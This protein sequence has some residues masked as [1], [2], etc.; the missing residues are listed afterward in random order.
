M[1]T[2]QHRRLRN[3]RFS[4]SFIVDRYEMLLC[5]LDLRIEA[6]R[7]SAPKIACLLFFFSVDATS[8]LWSDP[9]YPAVFLHAGLRC[10]VARNRRSVWSFVSCL[11]QCASFE[12][13]S[14]GQ[15]VRSLRVSRLTWTIG[16]AE[17]DFLRFGTRGS[18]S[19]DTR[20]TWSLNGRDVWIGSIKSSNDTPGYRPIPNYILYRRCLVRSMLIQTCSSSKFTVDYVNSHHRSVHSFIGARTRSER[21]KYTRTCLAECIL[22]YFC[23]SCIP[24]CRCCSM[25]V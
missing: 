24:L 11:V 25:R 19:G 22:L 8:E 1:E 5:V 20:H 23:F 21:S 7:V 14:T 13:R 6:K 9:A 17:R 4:L 2:K 16:N 18:R 10:T 3:R 12:T 15:I